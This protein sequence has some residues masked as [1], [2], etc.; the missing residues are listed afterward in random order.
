MISRQSRIAVAIAFGLAVSADAHAA[1]LQSV[2]AVLA[3]M[4]E[5]DAAEARQARE[6]DSAVALMN[7]IAAFRS[8]SAQLKATDAAAQWLALWDRAVARRG[9][10]EEFD[11]ASVDPVTQEVVA[12]GSLLASLPDPQA[13]PAIRAQSVA[14]AAK[15]PN[16]ARALGLRLLA[17]VLARDADAARKTLTAFERMAS[18]EGSDDEDPRLSAVRD[19]R[20][21]VDEIYG[22]REHMAEAFRASVRLHEQHRIPYE[23]NA[24]DLVGLV[25]EAKAEAMLLEALAKPVKL[26]VW[27]GEATKSLARKLALREVANLR[28]PQWA[29]VDDIGTAP[30]YE[31]LQARFGSGGSPDDEMPGLKIPGLSGRSLADLYYMLDMIVAGRQAEAEA[32]LL[33]LSDDPQW[34][35]DC[36]PAM[37]ELAR[38]GQA[39]AVLAFTADMLGKRP[40]LPLW[41]FHLEQ[42][43]AQGRSKEAIA[44]LDKVLKR[45]DLGE[46][47]RDGLMSRRIDAL[48]ADDQVDAAA[49]GLRALLAAPP[50]RNE[51]G[52]NHRMTAAL[53]LAGLGR[54]LKRP[55]W[56]KVGLDF[57]TKV[58]ALPVSRQQPSGPDMLQPLVAELRRQ[59]LVDRAQALMLAQLE[60]ERTNSAYSGAGALMVN[61]IR[62]DALVELVGLYDATGRAAR[63]TCGGC[64]TRCRAGPHSTWANSPPP[65]IRW[66]RRSA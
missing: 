59:G 39:G 18:T 45:T 11:E 61:A 9:S 52:L 33:R 17:E 32:V 31:A 16:D 19:V 50:S 41:D 36:R 27:Q 10:E 65:R 7:D 63:P 56:S 30:L 2:D 60:S 4:A 35:L 6:S 66:E 26:R 20:E 1:E 12:P 47:L 23:V 46:P 58:V 38:R 64:S 25:G 13:W 55:E 3:R 48:L 29:L 57:G 62:R 22:S 51:P 49:A 40:Q 42:A 8:R 43:A 34:L 53:K 14:R 24:P 37:A 44:L 54:V 15:A 5:R 21:L 28:K